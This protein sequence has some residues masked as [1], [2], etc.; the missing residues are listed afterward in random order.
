M[1]AINL[2]SSLIVLGGTIFY[3]YVFPKKKINLFVLLLIISILPIISIFRAGA[4]ESGDF[5]IQI[6][7]MMSFYNSLKEGILIPSWAADLNATYGNPLFIFNYSLSYY[8]ICFLHF[9]GVSFI[10]STKIYLALTLYLSGIFMYLF[11]HKIS[12]NNLVAFTA[13]IFYVFVPYH[14]I[15]VHFRATFGE[16]AIFTITPLLFLFIFKFH[17]KNK[18]IY[19]LV[20]SIISVLM[21]SSHPVLAIIFLG[22]AFL[23]I[24]LLELTLKRFKAIILV[25]LALIVG[26]LSTM[27]LWAPYIIYSPYMFKFSDLPNH[28]VDFYN[29]SLLFYSPWRLGLLFQGPKGELA[30]IIGYTQLLVVALFLPDAC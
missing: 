5:N 4:Y 15:D 6:Y 9:L 30:Q 25:T 14:L 21:I 12:K 20:I 16:S 11:M 10:T 24:S 18:F 17:E 2:I 22:I 13:S 1:V 8:F 7:R 28:A 29:F 26:G 23:Y 27:Y 19:L 3:R